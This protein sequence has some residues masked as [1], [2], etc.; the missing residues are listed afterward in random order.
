MKVRGVTTT[1][2]PG[3]TPKALQ[4]DIQSDRAVRQ[5]DG[6]ARSDPLRELALELAPFLA[7]PVIDP[8]RAQHGGDRL[9]LLFGEARPWRERRSDHCQPFTSGRAGL[10]TTVTPAGTSLVTTAPMP[11][12]APWPITSGRSGVP[13]R[14]VAPVPM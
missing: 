11:T 3:P 5:R 14:I 2:S 13:C 7:G 1:S 4:R 12:I 9:G 6:V 10:P 8:I